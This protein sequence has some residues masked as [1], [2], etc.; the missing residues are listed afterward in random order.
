MVASKDQ[1]FLEFILRSALIMTKIKACFRE[2]KQNCKSSFNELQKPKSH[3][4]LS[5]EEEYRAK[6]HGEQ[7]APILHGLLRFRHR[8]F[9]SRCSEFHPISIFYEQLISILSLY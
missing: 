4:I 8:Q 6:F 2:L 5:K 7:S 9:L 3:L 1:H